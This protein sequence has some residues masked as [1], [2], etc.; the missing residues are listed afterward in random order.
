MITE[1]DT[2][3]KYVLPRLDAAG[4]NQAPHDVIAQRTCIDGR[5]QVVG[6]MERTLL[7]L[8]RKT[9]TPPSAGIRRRLSAEEYCE[10]LVDYRGWPPPLSE[11]EVSHLM[12]ANISSGVIDWS[13]FLARALRGPI[14][15]EATFAQATEIT[16]KRLQHVSLPI[17]PV[18]EQRGIVAYL[19]NLQTK[20]DALKRLSAV[21]ERAF[22]GELV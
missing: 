3:S 9:L 6:E 18:A 4:W 14:V 16:A 17:P 22:R 13:A 21:L 5:I 12:G 15:R 1:A 19:D 20:V 10:A 11:K 7:S 8:T 2:C